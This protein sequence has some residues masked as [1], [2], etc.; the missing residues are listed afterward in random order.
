MK[1]QHQPHIDDERRR[2]RNV[3]VIGI[4]G[5][6]TIWICA[7]KLDGVIGVYALIVVCVLVGAAAAR[8]CR[9]VTTQQRRPSRSAE[10]AIEMKKNNN[11]DVP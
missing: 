4:A 11:E 6:L 9:R 8:V 2:I 1:A 10:K 3:L 7:G 5:G